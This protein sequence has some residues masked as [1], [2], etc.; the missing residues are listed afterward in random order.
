MRVLI[1]LLDCMDFKVSEGDMLKIK[2]SYTTSNFQVGGKAQQ[3]VRYKDVLK[4]L[5][6][7]GGMWTIKG[8]QTETINFAEIV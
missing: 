5:T 2:D 6:Y 3:L 1:N 4:A 7:Q 8:G